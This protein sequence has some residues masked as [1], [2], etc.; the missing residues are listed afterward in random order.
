MLPHHFWKGDSNV[1]NSWGINSVYKK[2]FRV[3]HVVWIRP[4]DGWFKLN[5]D[6]ASK[7]NP[8]PVGAGGILRNSQGDTIFAFFSFL[9]YQ[10]NMLTELHAVVQG[11][12]LC[13]DKG[14]NHVWIQTLLAKFQR[15][16]QQ[17]NIKISYIFRKGN[18]VS[19]NLANMVVD[20]QASAILSSSES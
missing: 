4:S 16:R 8:G 10:T 18:K 1:G 17:M 13:L 7:G 15:V 3:Q 19:D 2:S 6:G 5:C 9:G 20:L 12:E 14:F 11:T